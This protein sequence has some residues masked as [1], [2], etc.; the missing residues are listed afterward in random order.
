MGKGD[1]MILS[2]IMFK[3]M[4]TNRLLVLRTGMGNVVWN[5]LNSFF[6]NLEVKLWKTLK[7]S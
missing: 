5:D 3:L 7:S 6:S 2:G 1:I 4:H